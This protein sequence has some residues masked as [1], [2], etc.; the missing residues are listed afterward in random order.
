MEHFGITYSFV[1]DAPNIFGNFL[2]FVGRDQLGENYLTCSGMW[3]SQNTLG[4]KK[5]LHIQDI[6]APPNQLYIIICAKLSAH[7]VMNTARRIN[8]G[9]F[10]EGGPP[11][12]E[13]L[14]LL[15]PSLPH[16][17][18]GWCSETPTQV[19]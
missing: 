10:R 9:Y 8:L 7:M 15:L 6:Q 17:L 16:K 5:A 18:F 19:A 2:L 4:K 14:T 3:G 12:Q 13:N 1:A 11:S